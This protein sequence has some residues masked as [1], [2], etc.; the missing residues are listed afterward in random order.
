MVGALGKAS[1][2]ERVKYNANE[3]YNAN[4]ADRYTGTSNII[5]KEMTY[6]AL[7]LLGVKVEYTLIPILPDSPFL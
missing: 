7:E 5:Q 3:Y 4:E 2:P 6:K 1:R